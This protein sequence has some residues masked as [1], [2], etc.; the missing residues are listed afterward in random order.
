MDE[1][2]YSHTDNREV[3]EIYQTK[4]LCIRG[5]VTIAEIDLTRAAYFTTRGILPSFKII[6]IY[7]ITRQGTRLV[8]TQIP[9]KIKSDQL[10]DFEGV[11]STI[12][13]KKDML[14]VLGDIKTHNLA[15]AKKSGPFLFL[16]TILSVGVIILLILA[17][18]AV[19]N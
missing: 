4:I 9:F 10:S 6:D 12:I 16:G 14:S 19:V 5:G 11:L 17:F 8:G 1:K 18:S 3:I 7:P 13:P 15:F 2:I